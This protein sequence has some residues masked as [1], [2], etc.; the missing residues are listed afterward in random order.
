[1]EP[2]IRK[3][4]VDDYP[5]L[6]KIWEDAVRQSHDFLTDKEIG[7]IRSQLIPLYF[8]NVNLYVICDGDGDAIAGFMGLSHDKIE[9][10][11]VN[12]REHGK[13]FGT[14]LI[15]MA[16]DRDIKLVDVNEQNPTALGFYKRRGF[17]VISRDETD[18]AGRPFPILHMSMD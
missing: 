18:D 3:G 5:T 1:M 13:G 4:T 16:I 6:V 12:P 8:P 7:D 9:M 17:K 2:K 15:S 11:F 14:S 10:L